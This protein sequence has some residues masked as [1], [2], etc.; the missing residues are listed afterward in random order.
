VQ[1]LTKFI[2]IIIC[3]VSTA[4][5][6]NVEYRKGK[7]KNRISIAPIASIYKNHPQLTTGTKANAGFCGSYKSEI[8][9]GRRSSLLMGL[10]YFSQGFTF[11]GYY[12]APGYTYLFDKTYAYTHEV[13]VHELQLPVAMKR[14]FNNEK[15]NKYTP[16][17][18]VG[19]GLRYILNSY[20]VISNDSTETVVYDGK[21]NM[22]FEYQVFT[23]MANTLFGGKGKSIT[24]KLNS[25][26][27][28]GLGMQYNLRGSGKALYFELSYKYGISRLHYTGYNNSNNLNI[29][30]SHLLF[31]FGLR[32]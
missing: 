12:V 1:T 9:L 13:S 6:Q 14:A 3:T 23:Q 2:L 18:F 5:A 16:Y 19:A 7:V 17:Y 25:F 11:H 10:D 4:M 15:D 22:D 28:G 31:N 27:Y 21:G 30:D 24:R 20:Y 32:F 29:K 8:L 26:I